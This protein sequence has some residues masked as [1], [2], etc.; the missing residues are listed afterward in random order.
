LNDSATYG[1]IVYNKKKDDGKPY[2]IFPEKNL[3]DCLVAGTACGALSAMKTGGT[4]GQPTHDELAAFPA[5]DWSLRP[6]H[7]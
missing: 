6:Q 3:Y 7:D 4:G 1:N 2:P 5:R